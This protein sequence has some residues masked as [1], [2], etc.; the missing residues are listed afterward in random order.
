MDMAV[1]KSLGRLA[2]IA[3]IAPITDL[4]GD[5]AKRD[6]L[7]AKM[8]KGLESRLTTGGGQQLFYSKTWS[9]MIGY[10]ASYGSDTRLSDPHFH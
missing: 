7:V 3:P 2:A 9:A 6:D 8:K 4:A 1:L 5:I 10:P